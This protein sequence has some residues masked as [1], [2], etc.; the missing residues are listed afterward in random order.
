MGHPRR[1]DAVQNEGKYVKHR[2]YDVKLSKLSNR[3]HGYGYP[4]VPKNCRPRQNIVEIIRPRR[5]GQRHPEKA[6]EQQPPGRQSP[7]A[8]RSPSLPPTRNEDDRG[9]R[10]DS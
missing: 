10:S 6:D 8:R 4:H 9:A 1:E 2:V 7:P 3:N 5:V